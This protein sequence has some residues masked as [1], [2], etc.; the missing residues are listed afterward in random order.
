MSYA[1]INRCANDAA[2]QGRVTACA[3]QEGAS[4]PSAWMMWY[5][6]WPVA[7]TPDIAAAY[8]Y[9]L[10]ASNPE[11]GSDETVITDAMILSAVQA[12]WPKVEQ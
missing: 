3:A 10:A 8:E 9:A 5:L 7:A 11:P 4:D 12:H 1:S 2:F 6:R